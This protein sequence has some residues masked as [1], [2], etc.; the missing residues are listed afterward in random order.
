MD[1]PD[2]H[3]HGAPEG[4]GQHS[5]AAVGWRV[6]AWRRGSNAHMLLDLGARGPPSRRDC[7]G[8]RSVDSDRPAGEP[9][10]E[11]PERGCHRDNELK[12]VAAQPEENA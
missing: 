9:K 10:M 5:W 4:V 11:R 3:W 7:S 1:D 8:N 6:D 12:L 2:R